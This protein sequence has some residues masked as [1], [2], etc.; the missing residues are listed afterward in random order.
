MNINRARKIAHRELS[1]IHSIHAQGN[2][3][4]VQLRCA[5]GPV[6]LIEPAGKGQVRIGT[7]YQHW[8]VPI[9]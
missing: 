2:A 9:S 6:Y 7:Q 4:R 3:F 8:I 5:E 1:D